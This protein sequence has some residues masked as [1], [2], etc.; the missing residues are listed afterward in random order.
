MLVK[1]GGAD[2]R[3]WEVLNLWRV[4]YRTGLFR[5]DLPNGLKDGARAAL[6]KHQ[7]RRAQ[8]GPA[9]KTFHTRISNCAQD[10]AREAMLNAGYRSDRSRWAE[11]YTACEVALDWQLEK[12]EAKSDTS[13]GHHL[14]H[15]KWRA[16]NV[17]F[18]IGIHPA[19][20]LIARLRFGRHVTER[21]KLRVVL[22]MLPEN[23]QK[24]MLF[25]FKLLGK[26]LP[27]DAV[28]VRAVRQGKGYDVR[29]CV[30]MLRPPRAGEKH[31]RLT[32]WLD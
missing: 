13:V 30:A 7:D 20:F 29:D 16:T 12:A 6:R 8:R 2:C 22:E 4:A 1:L 24:Q 19:R 31:W 23:Y 3:C 27:L 14:R 10:G 15:R 5:S 32:R 9:P 18:Q 21:G 28:L 26:P 11:T 17:T 25:N